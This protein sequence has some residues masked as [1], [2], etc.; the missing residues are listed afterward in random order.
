MSIVK[1]EAVTIAGRIEDFDSIIGK[2][3]YGREIH[4]ETAM[5]VLSDKKN[6]HSF[7]DIGH[8]DTIVK[9]LLIF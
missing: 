9:V 1:M 3:V 5:S 4:L 7:A 6:L 2:Y 8:Y